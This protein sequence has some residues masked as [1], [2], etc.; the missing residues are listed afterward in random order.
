MT[1]TY[2]NS[3]N[4]KAINDDDLNEINRRGNNIED[5]DITLDEIG[6]NDDIENDEHNTNNED[7]NVQ[8]RYER[9]NG[10]T[11]TSESARDNTL[12]R[13]GDTTA[14]RRSQRTRTSTKNTIYKDY[15]YKKR[16]V[17]IF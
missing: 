7:N 1:K 12:Q 3:N 6:V 13:G 16:S 4:R 8:Y 17:V 14:N 15:V 5:A 2:D 9:V 11:H 10:A